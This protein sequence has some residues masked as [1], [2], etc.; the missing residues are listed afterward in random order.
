MITTDR[1]TIRVAFQGEPGAF[2]E[3]AAIQLLGESITTV[4]R[5]TFEAI[6]RS[7]AEGAADAILAPVENSLAGSVVR[8]FDLLL[9]S[10]LA[11]VAETIL[12]IEMQLI[13]LPGAS[14]DDIRSVASHPMA[15]AQCERFF[16]A[17]AKWKRVP[18]E[19]TAGSVR[20]MI[21]S[22]DK[23]RAAIAGRRA[24][25][26]YHGVI[27][28]ERIQDNPENFTRFVLLVPD[29]EA[30][31]W[32]SAEARKTS[33]AMRLA[34]RP[35][36]LLASLGP[37]AKH[38]VNL[39]KIESRPIHGRPWEYQFFIDLE[40]EEAASLDHALAEVRKATSELRVLGRYAAASR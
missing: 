18:A 40:A 23:S 39:L 35:G 22:G 27:L 17:H 36:A 14:L 9:E 24:A 3:A 5:A 1:K 34:H 33:L 29:R 8:V 7:I 20:E 11:I 32:P 37:F 15:L 13:A 28:A 4:P 25:E 10:Q 16:A 19:D 12:P 26:H 30:R 38:G 6:F 21:S 31:G 2:S